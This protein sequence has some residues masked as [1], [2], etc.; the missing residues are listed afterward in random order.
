L[1]TLSF[2]T[3]IYLPGIRPVSGTAFSTAVVVDESEAKGG[4][5]SE[6]PAIR[7]V[8]A[9]TVATYEIIAWN[10]MGF[11]GYVER[12]ISR[13]TCQNYRTG[14]RGDVATNNLAFSTLPAKFLLGDV[15][16]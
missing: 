8:P 3:T 2:R 16:V 10:F 12:V 1:P 11:P 13:N 7:S 15:S 4:V 14:Q 6:Q 5:L 9:T